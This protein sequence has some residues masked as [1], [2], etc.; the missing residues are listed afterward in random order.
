MTSNYNEDASML[1]YG[2]N[3]RR[4]I[5]LEKLGGQKVL[6]EAI[7]IFYAKQLADDRLM[8][9][10]RGVNVEVIK[11]HNFNLMSLAFTALPENFDL[12]ALLL[13][14]HKRLFEMGLNE[15]YFDI[16]L[17]HFEDTLVE[18]N[19]DDELVKEALEIVSPLRLVFAQGY[20]E[21]QQRKKR[22]D[23]TRQAVL[24]LIVAAAAFGVFKFAQSKKK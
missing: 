21:A 11:W 14:R 12:Q 4:A 5:M 7:D 15:D 3:E 23:Q 1:H 9:F 8:Y 22:A 6:R 24:V 10:F 19:V 16:V 2:A 13:T 17:Q 18:M 20:R